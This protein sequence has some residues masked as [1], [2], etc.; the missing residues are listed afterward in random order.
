MLAPVVCS[1][2][3][4]SAM[5]LLSRPTLRPMEAPSP[6]DPRL[7]EEGAGG[8]RDRR[9]PQHARHLVVETSRCCLLGVR[10]L[11]A[12]GVAAH[13]HADSRVA[14]EGRLAPRAAIPGATAGGWQDEDATSVR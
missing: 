6:S 10:Q 5:S 4:P 11:P 2:P 14:E 8:G 1:P 9:T 12:C 7:L 3:P 13:K